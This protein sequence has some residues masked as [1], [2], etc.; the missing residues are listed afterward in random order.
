MADEQTANSVQQ[1]HH[2]FYDSLL[3]TGAARTQY[4]RAGK[5]Q[6]LGF[7]SGDF[8]VKQTEE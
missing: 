2:T 6:C 1:F 4:R 7:S 3:Q 8:P 5:L